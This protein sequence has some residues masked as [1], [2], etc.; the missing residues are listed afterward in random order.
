[1]PLIRKDA[2]PAAPPQSDANALMGGNKEARWAAAR[3]MT[4]HEHVPALAAALV[5]EKEVG[6]R[7]AILTALCRIATPESM[8]A[9]IPGVRSDEASIRRGALDAL[10][11]APTAAASHL[12]ALLADADADVRLLTC[13]VVRALPA[14]D[15]TEMLSAVLLRET[16]ANVCAAAAD[17]LADIGTAEAAPALRAAAGRFPDEAFLQ[18]AI[19]G[20]L[21]R[22]AQDRA[23]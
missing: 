12:P 1:M 19:R 22:L 10:R 4:R 3:A 2:A 6:V 9:I 16:E 14:S 18:F 21:E 5:E 17:V 20:A 11:S 15:A 13:E 23:P 7:E 8:A